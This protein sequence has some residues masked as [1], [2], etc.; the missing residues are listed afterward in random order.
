MITSNQ[1]SV[2]NVKLQLGKL[3]KALPF[4]R[5]NSS[6][7]TTSRKSLHLPNGEAPNDFND[8]GKAI[9]SSLEL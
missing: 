6:R 5:F 8:F 2:I 9:Y 4:L 3:A 1:S 7:T